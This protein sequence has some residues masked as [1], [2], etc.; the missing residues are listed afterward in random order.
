L[1]ERVEI[2]ADAKTPAYLLLTDTFDP[3]WSA[4]VDGKPAT[5]RPAY[6]AFRAIFLPI[7]KHR[8][9]F[10]YEP[11][12]FREGLALT[13]VGL[14]AILA[15]LAWPKTIVEPDLSHVPLPWPRFWPWIFAGLLL[16]FVI[17][18]AVKFGPNGPAIHPRWE[19]AWHRFTWSAD[20]DA[21]R[22][23]SKMLG[24]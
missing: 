8:V 14:I 12:G 1:P 13:V 24:R 21:I 3:G 7:G 5:I 17:A 4:T 10:T 16:V 9:V 20:I 19:G 23:M 2:A 22:P 15:C 11:A 6:A 18:S